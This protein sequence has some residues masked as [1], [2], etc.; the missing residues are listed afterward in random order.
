MGWSVLNCYAGLGGEITG[1]ARARNRFSLSLW[2]EEEDSCHIRRAEAAPAMVLV[3][4]KDTGTGFHAIDFG[5][6]VSSWRIG[7]ATL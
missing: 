5:S 7:P 3:Q 4:Y 1:I 2:R 6:L